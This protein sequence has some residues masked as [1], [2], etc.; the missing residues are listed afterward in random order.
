MKERLHQGLIDVKLQATL[1]QSLAIC[2]LLA[3]AVPYR[4]FESY[5]DY[6][7]F[8]NL[9]YSGFKAW[10]DF[11]GTVAYPVVELESV[12]AKELLSQ[13]EDKSV[14]ANILY[15]HLSPWADTPYGRKRRE[16]LDFLIDWTKPCVES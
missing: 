2:D 4:T 5:E 13:T 10:P 15:H 9:L 11:S 6:C 3:Y 16:L 8:C 1:E 7:E 12:L 14:I